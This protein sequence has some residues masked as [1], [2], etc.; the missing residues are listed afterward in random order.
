MRAQDDRP[1]LDRARRH[2]ASHPWWTFVVYLS[3]VIGTLAA[4]EQLAP[5]PWWVPPTALNAS[6]VLYL[7]FAV[8]IISQELARAG[9]ENEP[10]PAGS[11]A[12]AAPRAEERSISSTAEVIPIRSSVPR[13]DVAIIGRDRER[14]E[15][16]DALRQH[17]VVTLTGTGGVGKTFLALNVAHRRRQASETVCFIDLVRASYDPQV[18]NAVADALDIRAVHGRPLLDTL[19]D[20]LWQQDVLLVLDRCEHVRGGVV[21]IVSRMLAECDCVRFLATSR[22]RLDVPDE[23]AI[24]ICPFQLPQVGS[25]SPEEA[26]DLPAVQL[27]ELRARQAWTTFRL[28]R[29]NYHVVLQICKRLGGL[30]LAITIA[31]SQLDTLNLQ[32]IMT[33]IDRALDWKGDAQR[34]AEDQLTL[35]A[36]ID[37]S[38]RRLS[39]HNQRVFRQLAVFADV[40]TQEAATLW[41]AGE[42]AAAPSGMVLQR[43]VQASLVERLPDDDGPTRYR[44]LEPIRT[45]AADLLKREHELSDAQARHAK[46]FLEKARAAEPLLRSSDREPYLEDLEHSHEDLRAAL[47]WSGVHGNDPAL[48]HQL[49][50]S[51]VWFWNF[52][53]Y[54]VEGQRWTELARTWGSPDTLVEAKILYGL[55]TFSFLIGK[56]PS[57]AQSLTASVEGF[58]CAAGR[59]FKGYALTVLAMTRLFLGNV[60]EALPAAEEAVNVFTIEDDEWGRALALNDLANVL[61]ASSALYAGHPAQQPISESIQLWESLGDRWGLSLALTTLGDLSLGVGDLAAAEAALRQALDLQLARHDKWGEGVARMLLGHTLVLAGDLEQA[62]ENL[63][64]SWRLNVALGRAQ[65]QARCL[66]GF[67]SLAAAGG[68][69]DA[70]ARFFGAAVGLRDRLGIILPDGDRQRQEETINV[71]CGDLDEHA[72]HVA[73]DEGRLWSAGRI[74]EEID[75]HWPEDKQIARRRVEVKS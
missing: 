18:V 58:S 60:A 30:P 38:Y 63:R 46:F 29:D 36:T 15:V 56:L 65:I 75:A 39:L 25:R 11:S 48:A 33:G 73:R 66:D 40:F 64:L 2:V 21:T 74:Q 1:P 49:V 24:D 9:S 44:M 31:A 62:Q 20:A 3:A 8:L 13:S 50:A 16:E 14:Q 28:D 51:L 12:V 6:I 42:S 32:D 52:R 4:V 59:S 71:A 17:R 55:G 53:G 19:I 22:E 7:V 72:C 47:T 67:A 43:L 27:F 57:A 35:R 23:I 10:L 45:F 26:R 5:A 61:L 34:A 54:L 68:R 70:A 37:W 69:S 41:E